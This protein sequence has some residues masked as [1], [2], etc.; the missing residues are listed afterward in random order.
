MSMSRFALVLLS[1]LS[2]FGCYHHV[3]GGPEVSKT[4][5]LE[6]FS[7]VR[8]ETGVPVKFSPGANAVTINAQQ[9]VEEN[10]QAIVSNDALVVRLKPGVSVDSFEGTE[11]LLAADGVTAFEVR[12]GSKLEAT[13]LTAPQL[14][15]EL[16]DGSEASLAGVTTDLNLESK[17]GSRLD[18]AKL[19][20]ELV[21]LDVS[22]GSTVDVNATRSVAGNAW[23][24]STVRVFGGGDFSA[25]SVTGGSSLLA[26]SN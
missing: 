25:V 6:K 24:G 3:D 10:L 1:A 12:H 22:G 15:V 23:T 4:R 16:T 13:G 9:R 19:V 17:S 7:R 2:L 14:F 26:A 11:I 18:A 8:L 20:S 21:S 5:T